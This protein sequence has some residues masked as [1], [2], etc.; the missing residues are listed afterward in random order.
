MSVA[1]YTITVIV[2]ICALLA[3]QLIGFHYYV[4]T[5]CFYCSNSTFPFASLPFLSI[6]LTLYSSL[7]DLSKCPLYIESCSC[8]TRFF[9]ARMILQSNVVEFCFAYNLWTSA[10][11]VEWVLPIDRGLWCIRD[12]VL[13]RDYSKLTSPLEDTSQLHRHLLLLI[14]VMA[15]IFFA[16]SNWKLQNVLIK[17]I[18]PNFLMFWT[19]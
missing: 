2:P 7:P 16:S 15:N 14:L 12:S 3:K 1:Y 6:T 19:F 9:K 10:I 17:M 11:L 5:L 8:V 18:E 4:H 13:D